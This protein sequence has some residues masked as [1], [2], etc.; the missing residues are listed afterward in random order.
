MSK[1]LISNGH[2]NDGKSL[3]E[4]VFPSYVEKRKFLKNKKCFNQQRTISLLSEKMFS[5]EKLLVGI[6]DHT[7]R[8]DFSKKGQKT[9]YF[10]KAVLAIGIVINLHKKRLS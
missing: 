5:Y 10:A 4:A 3:D 9:P 8:S 6:S 2:Y 1:N 7:K